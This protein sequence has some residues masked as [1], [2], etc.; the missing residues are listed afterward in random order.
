[1]KR[2][3]RNHSVEFKA[4]VALAAVREES[5]SKLRRAHRALR[6][7]GSLAPLLLHCALGRRGDGEHLQCIH[8]L[9]L[10]RCQGQIRIG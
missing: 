7:C 10:N 4:K 8:V 3:R 9:G 6:A 1:M 2:K 5:Y